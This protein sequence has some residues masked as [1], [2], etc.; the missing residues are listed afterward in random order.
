VEL[1]VN[2][3]DFVIFISELAAVFDNIKSHIQRGVYNL[4]KKQNLASILSKKH[5]LLWEAFLDVNELEVFID[6]NLRVR[7]LTLLSLVNHFDFKFIIFIFNNSIK[8]GVRQNVIAPILDFASQVKLDL[9]FHE[10]GFKK[11]IIIVQ[12]YLSI[13]QEQ[14]RV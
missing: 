7:N 5:L 9:P 10:I 8:S 2:F 12:V 11:M 1:V 4:F 13:C 14:A 3:W 6:R